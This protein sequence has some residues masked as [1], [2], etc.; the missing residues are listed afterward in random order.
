MWN[1]FIKKHFIAKKKITKHQLELQRVIIFL[2]GGEFE[3]LQELQNVIRKRKWADAIG[4]MTPVNLLGVGL[5]Q[6]FNL[7]KIQYLQAQ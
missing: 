3:I 2:A 6:T 1:T 4:K 7:S 5:P